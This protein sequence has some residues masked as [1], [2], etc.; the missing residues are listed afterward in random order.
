MSDI[1][2][3]F[4]LTNLGLGVIF[5]LFFIFCFVG[6][7][8]RHME[9]PRVGVKLELQLPAYTAATVAPDPSSICDLHHTAHSNAGSL[10]H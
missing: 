1:L 9:V 6:L 4:D 7:H 3:D 8:S 5:F 10:T 2:K